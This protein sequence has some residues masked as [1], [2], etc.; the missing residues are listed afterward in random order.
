MSFPSTHLVISP[1]NHVITS[2]SRRLGVKAVHL[3][4][5]AKIKKTA[6]DF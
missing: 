1:H 5:E 2:G 4:R 3:E 6:V